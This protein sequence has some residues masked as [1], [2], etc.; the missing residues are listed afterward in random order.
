M[1][2]GQGRGERIP[3]ISITEKD[4]VMNDSIKPEFR[5]QVIDID[6]S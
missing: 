6:D 1:E 2:E 3:T 5:L 4:R